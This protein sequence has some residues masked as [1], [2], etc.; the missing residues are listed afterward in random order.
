VKIGH[1]DILEFNHVKKRDEDYSGRELLK[2]SAIESQLT[3]CRF[4]GVRVD[5][6]ALGAGRRMSHFTE[7]VFD[8]S[9]INFGAG[10]RVRFEQCSFRDTVLRGWFCFDVELVDCTFTGRLEKAVFNG[11][12][13]EDHQQD[14]GRRMN[15]FRGNDFS[16]MELVDVAFRTGIDLSLQRLPSGPGYLYVPDAGP[17]VRHARA[18]VE[19]WTDAGLRKNASGLLGT[20][21]SQVNEGQAQLILR[22]ADWNGMANQMVLDLLAG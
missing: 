16:E 1:D 3:G 7:C 6:A 15:E 4:D 19:A 14:L 10:G 11:T 12:V 8:H 18:V 20:L 13:R 2:I 21:E 22:K 17:V 9:R 5:S